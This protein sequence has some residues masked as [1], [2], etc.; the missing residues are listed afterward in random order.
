MQK[1]AHFGYTLTAFAS[2]LVVGLV[3][4]ALVAVAITNAPIP[5]LN[6]VK[7]PTELIQPAH[8]GRLP[9]PNKEL[10][11]PPSLKP[12]TDSTSAIKLTRTDPNPPSAAQKPSGYQLQV[13]AYRSE[14]DADSMRA[15]L[16]LLG[17][18]ARVL[19]LNQNGNRLYRV[20]IGPYEK[21]ADL[22]A[23]VQL[24]AEN[25]IESQV[26]RP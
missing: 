5:F 4:A 9:D 13:G 6:K 18:D 23:I 1:N 22:N 10:Y 15:R 24:L 25:R 14:G 2:G 20:R 17:I 11:A 19:P 3:I 26:I 16:A 7:A 12:D 8:D 21:E